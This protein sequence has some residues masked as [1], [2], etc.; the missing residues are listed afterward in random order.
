[1][2]PPTRRDW[3]TPELIAAAQKIIEESKGTAGRTTMVRRL[4]LTNARAEFLME[5]VHGKRPIPTPTPPEPRSPNGEKPP[6]SEPPKIL[7][8]LRQAHTV[9]EL[10]DLLDCSPARARAELA[11]LS[12]SGYVL[13]ES[14]GR[15]W[16]DFNPA[17]AETK[18]EI[19]A[20]EN[21]Q[22]VRFGFVSDTH[23]GSTRQQITYLCED[24]KRFAD[25]G[26]T[27]VLH[28]GDVLAGVGVYRG[29]SSDLFLHRYDDQ[30]EYA[31][32]RYPKI[33]GITTIA[34]GGNHDL[35]GLR[36]NGTDPLKRIAKE[37]PD[38]RYLGP[39]SAWLTLGALRIYLLHPD[40]GPSYAKSYR[41]Q[42]L[43]ESFTG[44]EKPHV[45]MVG[46]WHGRNYLDE[47]NIHL[48]LTGC[49]EAQ[50]DY[51]RRKILS[52][53]I[54]GGIIEIEVEGVEGFHAMTPTFYRHM[55]PVEGD[56]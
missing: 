26:I 2:A 1:M 34:I 6:G 56:R 4:G 5:V 29:Q 54:G 47:R 17:P 31:L 22:A 43:A 37:R 27:T 15:F 44:G 42:K 41:L 53:V 10:A 16:V 40:G 30:I 48:F 36:S 18:V 33:D 35:A 46:H 52:P 19:P 50:T 32:E 9:E 20:P 11:L 49:Y 8:H 51:E 55:T 3:L 13:Q 24:Y 14:A 7:R 21:G 28:L 39:Y 12:E 23:I 38:I 45:A 25:A